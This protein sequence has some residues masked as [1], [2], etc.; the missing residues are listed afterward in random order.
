M[1]GLR[2]LNPYRELEKRLGYK[3][4]DRALL[5]MALLHRSYRFEAKDVTTD[6]Q[7]LEFLGDAVVGFLVAAHLYRMHADI[8]EGILTELRSRVT[9]GKALAGVARDLGLG[10]YVKLGKGEE[11]AGGRLRETLL[12]DAMEAVIGAAYLDGGVKAAEKIVVKLL[13]PLIGATPHEDWE[14]NPKGKLQELS[15]RL[16]GRGPE[17]NCISEE[18]PPHQKQF[19]VEVI[20]GGALLGK[21]QG[22]SKRAAETEAAFAAV[23][24][25]MAGKSR[26]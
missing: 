23:R 24:K 10:D 2:K 19:R 26:L 18:G 17:Y 11:Q 12:A 16:Y 1:L 21:G 22:S 14:D 15:Q 9:S 6:N 3:F 13:I 7:R 20:V 4:G 5:D 25:L 8:D